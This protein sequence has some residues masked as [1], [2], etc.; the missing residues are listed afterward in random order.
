MNFQELTE[1]FLNGI[2]QGIEVYKG[3]YP[4]AEAPDTNWGSYLE[5]NIERVQA[6]AVWLEWTSEEAN[7]GRGCC[8]Y[9]THT[10][11]L[12]LPFAC[13]D[14]PE[15]WKAEELVKIE[16]AKKEAV[17][18]QK[19]EKERKRLEEIAAAEKKKIEKEENEKKLYEQ[20]REKYGTEKAS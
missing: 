19:A 10:H 15:T 13:I 2:N 17:A 16:E 18:R 4:F 3:V 6:G 7:C 12:K 1:K 5:A 8:G 20:L 11:S 9:S 14:S